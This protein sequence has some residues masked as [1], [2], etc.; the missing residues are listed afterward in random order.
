L[1]YLIPM[2][3]VRGELLYLFRDYGDLEGENWEFITNSS[4]YNY[5]LGE[6]T[7]LNDQLVYDISFEPKKRGLFEG[8]MYV[9][10]DTYALLQLDYAYA[11]GKDSEN[12]QLLGFGHSMNYKK[13][14]VIY[15]KGDQGYFLKYINVHQNES[16][17][18]DRNFSIL[19]KKKRFLIDKEL[20]EL[21]MEA[22]LKFDADL[23]WEALVL[24]RNEIS[25]EQYEEVKQPQAIKFEKKI[26][27]D[28]D[29]WHNSTVIAPTPELQKYQRQSSE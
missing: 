17:S 29:M 20:N 1:N 8:R 26:S 7:I 9:T 18:I 27:Y 19:K 6:V 2:N 10:T 15:E 25:K 28:S 23:Y 5:T 16:A 24:E 4:K 22:E 12:I 13:C 11:L 21:K 3:V 14:R